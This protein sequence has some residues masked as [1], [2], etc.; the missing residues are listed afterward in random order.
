M[1]KLLSFRSQPHSMPPF[2][3]TDK[4][5]L[6]FDVAA[7]VGW[8]FAPGDTIIGNVVRRA[9][10]VTPE[11]TLKLA[12]IGRVWT[13]ISDN[14]NIHSRE[15]HLLNPRLT[16]IFRG[17]LH[18]PEGSDEPL[19][20]AFS[21]EI[22]PEPVDTAI[23]AHT[24]EESLLPLDSDHLAHHVLPGSFSSLGISTS[25][26][27]HTECSIAYYL[28]AQLQYGR[29]GSLEIHNAISHITLRHPVE[30]QT[31]L[32]QL[33]TIEK[34]IIIRTHRLLPGMENA[35]L[36]LK[37][38]TLQ[39]FGSSKVPEFHCKIS[40]SLPRTIQLDRPSPIPIILNIMP[41]QHKTSVCIKDVA[42][43]VQINW[44]KMFIASSS[45]VIASNNQRNSLYSS[46]NLGLVSG[47]KSLE[48]PC[49]IS[50]GPD[51]GAINVGNMFQL[52]LHSFGLTAG[53]RHL[54]RDLTIY[55]DFITYNIKHSHYLNL[56]IS[57]TIAG[58]TQMVETSSPV[59]IIA[60]V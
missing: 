30:E 24:Q 51:N 21:I 49:T 14:N 41:R 54:S 12:L 36:S 26:G 22:P 27:A 32:L 42:Q 44:I 29:S 39:L 52:V 23:R 19:S 7:P 33:S 8:T 15:W 17:P 18:L 25:G 60:A 55:P 2:T 58:E 31:D 47:F 48:I 37:Q 9:P 59:K 45:Y 6:E 5:Q 10:I 46:V 34:Q 28:H 35:D 53:N 57:L 16:V 1:Q 56:T 4:L 43:N 40:V 50:T 11:A 13:S 20:W 3:T 38:K